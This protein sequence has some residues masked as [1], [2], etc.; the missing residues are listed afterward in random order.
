LGELEK[1]ERMGD[2]GPGAGTFPEKINC[3]NKLEK[4]KEIN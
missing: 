1:L 3:N 2:I 4:I